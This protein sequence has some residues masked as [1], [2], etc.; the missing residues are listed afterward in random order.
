MST[1]RDNIHE[2]HAGPD[3]IL[4]A[5]IITKVG[6]DAGFSFLTVAAKPRDAQKGIYEAVWTAQAV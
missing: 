2:L 6:S 3:G 5:D 1:S 4:G